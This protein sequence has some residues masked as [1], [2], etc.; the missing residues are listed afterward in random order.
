MKIVFTGGVTGGH[1]YPIISIVEE[2]HNI[3]RE[4][5]LIAPQIYF[6]SPTP[7]DKEA[8]FNNEIIYKK[9]PAGKLRRYASA[10][11]FFDG[12]KTSIGILKALWM[13]FWIYP[14]IIIGKGGHGSFPTLVAARI[15]GIPVLI[16]ESDSKPGRVNKWAGKFAK[17]IA[18]SYPD[19]AQ[20]FPKE[21]TAVTGNPVRA[22]IKTPA[23]DGAF[24]FLG[25][26]QGIPTILVL[27]GSQ[28]AKKIN[29]S[30]L[31]ALPTLVQNFQIIHQTGRE[32]FKE[33]SQTANLILNT[34]MYYKRYK[35]FDYMNDLAMRMSAGAAD[36][37]I[38][39]AGSTLF[40]VASWGIPSIVI[41][42][43]ET[44]SGDQRSNAFSYAR[45]GCGTVIEE[46]NLSTQILTA[47]ILRILSNPDTYKKMREATKEFAKPNA[48]R[49]IAEE[50]LEMVIQHEK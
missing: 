1:F 16:H 7:Y 29:D 33:V 19:A 41:P 46:N 10:M 44:V 34:S 23:K 14:D 39:R 43:P 11:N 15:L 3:V 42:I 8:L 18:L 12:I 50:I 37:V 22:Q 13:I 17:K 28:G 20:Y 35:P 36:L 21:K 47:E 9:T 27:G 31:D 45:S 30:I 4:N 5:K 49:L 32:N 26:E 2:I 25:L 38:T 48:S 6:I 40:E 24:E